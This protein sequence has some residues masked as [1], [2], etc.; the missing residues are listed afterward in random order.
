M[1]WWDEWKS[2]KEPELPL[3]WACGASEAVLALLP[4]LLHQA[5]FDWAVP[6]GNTQNLILVLGLL[7]GAETLAAI[8]MALGDLAGGLRIERVDAKLKTNLLSR[9]WKWTPLDLD[10]LGYGAILKGLEDSE[11]LTERSHALGAVLARALPALITALPLMFFVSWPLS[12]VRLLVLPLNW[13]LG[14]LFSERDRQLEKK[15]WERQRAFHTKVQ[16]TYEGI[17]T[18][19]VNSAVE[20]QHRDIEYTALLV[21]ES[22]SQRRAWSSLWNFTVQLL[23]HVGSV[24]VFFTAA[25]L[26]A[27]NQLSFG[28]F[29]AFQVIS[30]Q[31]VMSLGML[32]GISKTLFIT[33]NHKTR[34]QNLMDHPVEREHSVPYVTQGRV[35]LIQTL[36]LGFQYPNGNLALQKINMTL[37]AGERVAL[38]GPSGCGKTT[39]AHLFLA[40]YP[41]THGQ[42][43][44]KGVPYQQYSPSDLR[45]KMAAVLQD[46]ALWSATI[47]QNL[48]LNQR[49]YTTQQLEEALDR[50]GLLDWVRSLPKGLDTVW[51]AEGIRVSGGQRQRLALARAF[52]RQPQLLV[53]DEATS[54][55]DHLTENFIQDSLRAIPRNT[56]VITIAHRLKTIQDADCIYVMN[57]GQLVEAGHHESLLNY[58][59]FYAQLYTQPAEVGACN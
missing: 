25:A 52:L 27:F 49:I 47:R 44:W 20:A 48:C 8:A 41:H 36:G 38:V 28:R 13:K 16:E 57:R 34:Y 59:G 21:R 9:I 45:T 24:L 18:L 40:L 42:I 39:L 7:V 19:K 4:A 30:S 50:A 54:A 14:S 17:R 3:L 11:K 1:S 6:S 29:M 51:G 2:L 12:L 22:S 10:G 32:L 26:I 55:L 33:S 43:F 37:W 46:N 15:T 56:A 31:A 23:S 58:R 53:L 35:P 5:L